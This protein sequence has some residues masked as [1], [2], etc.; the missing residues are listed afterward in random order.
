[1]SR[2]LY[3]LVHIKLSVHVT[4]LMG[5]SSDGKMEPCEHLLAEWE[6]KN[7]FPYVPFCLVMV[8]RTDV[9]A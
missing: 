9:T 6:H 7:V 5:V 8:V 3:R 4:L 2:A 1:M